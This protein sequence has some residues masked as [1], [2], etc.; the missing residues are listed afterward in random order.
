MVRAIKF[1]VQATGIAENN[2]IGEL[3]VTGLGRAVFSKNGLDPFLE[4][5][6]TLW[7]I[8]WNISTLV[9]EPLFAWYFLLNDWPSSEI[10]RS[11]ILKHFDTHSK[12][13][14]RNL[15]EVTLAQHFDIFLHTYVPTRA[16][17]GVLQEDNLDC[18]LVE[19]ELIRKIGEREID[20]CLGRRESIYTFHREP[21]P[22]ITPELFLYCLQ[23]YWDKYLPYEKTMT[24]RDIALGP[25]SPGQV[26][27]L[28]EADIRERLDNLEV[29][30]DGVYRYTESTNLQQI[31]RNDD[32]LSTLPSLLKKIYKLEVSYA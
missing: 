29:Y 24:F 3:F 1:W 14:E 7:L 15:S 12:R 10:K 4:D 17:K 11:E 9:E 32:K 5:R 25:C 2:G 19:L 30:S 16:Q 22:E 21:K 31:H 20:D 26:F 8:H 6:R 27:K 18:P 28:P 13:L 23:S